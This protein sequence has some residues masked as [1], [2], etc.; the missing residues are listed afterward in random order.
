[1]R[2]WLLIGLLALAFPVR[3]Q[4]QAVGQKIEYRRDLPKS[5]ARLMPRG[6]K[7]LFWGRFTP[8][9]GSAPMAIHLFARDSKT[10]IKGVGSRRQIS[11]FSLDIFEFRNRRWKVLNS[12]AMR[13]QG[14][15]GNST[16]FA[17]RFSWI[18]LKNQKTPLLQFNV[19]VPDGGYGPIGIKLFL[20]FP[21]G[22]KNAGTVQALEFGEWFSSSSIGQT[23]VLQSNK[24]GLAQIWVRRLMARDTIDAPY[25]EYI[26]SW[27]AAQGR[28][29][30]VGEISNPI[31]E[32]G[33]TIGDYEPSRFGPTP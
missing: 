4:T 28:F 8:K 7:S 11:H 18:D 13:Y 25:P 32:A 1:M 12:G 3:A 33:E 20:S 5:V 15:I 23:V 14:R 29:W 19:F 17:A 2:K 24:A 16:R 22:W 31:V 10:E 30:P 26:F 21:Q 9:T 6:A 27:D